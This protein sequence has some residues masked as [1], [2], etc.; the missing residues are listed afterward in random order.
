[1]DEKE[2]KV[3]SNRYENL[4]RAI[5]VVFL[6]LCTTGIGLAVF[7]IF[8]FSVGGQIMIENGYYYLLL[9]C[10][11]PAGFL[12]LPGRS[13]D[14]QPKWYDLLLAVLVFGIGLYLFFNVSDIAEVGWRAPTSLPKFAFALGLFISILEGTRRVGGNIYFAVVIIISLY[15]VY[16]NYMPGIFW[17]FSYSFIDTVGFYA[18]GTEGILGIPLDVMGNIL[19]GFLLF[20]GV[21]MAT[22]GGKFFL[23]ISLALLGR[24]RG[25]PAKVAVLSSGLFGSLSGSI[26]SNVASTGS[27]TIPAMKRMGYPPHYAGAI[28]ACASTGGVLMPPVMG[29]V[30]FV[31]CSFLG[32]EY[33]TVMAAAFI[34]SLLYYFG[35]LVQVDAYAAKVGFKGLPREELPSIKE[36]LKEGWP[37]IFALLFL[38]WGLLYMRWGVKAAFYASALMF[39]LS[40]FRRET[41]LTPKR[42]IDT[43]VTVGSLI[44]QTTFLLLPMG[45]I[46][47]G[48]MITGVSLSF[49]SGFV[50][51]G[52]GNIYLILLVGVIACYIL[53]MVGMSIP[54]YIFLAV[55]MAPAIMEASA[56]TGGLNELAVHLFIIYYAMLAAITPPVAI[57]AFLGANMAGAPPLKT[58]FQAMRLG[59]VIYFIPFFFVFHPALILQGPILEIIYTSV[60]SFIGILL[61]GSGLEGYLV[62]LGKI[63]PLERVFLTISGFLISFPDL[64]T[65]FIGIFLALLIIISAMLLRRKKDRHRGLYSKEY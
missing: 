55:T 65:T 41:M 24:F 26:L 34:P 17:G 9:A 13:K 48:L 38:V 22:G 3:E 45:F 15:P 35:L 64:K 29:A 42:I 27:F 4:P 8:G 59:I 61:I 49:T 58:A 39:L 52:G 60:S 56:A 50:N 11:V 32:V 53:G 19:I 12:I 5:K 37:F 25:G 54:A 33:A 18:F 31:M 63:N 28:E 46:I 16:S 36:T 43:L 7:Q 30:A 47:C 44:S 2:T 40:F 20:A 10:F 6:L 21:M 23:S 62:K 14:T 51:L 57:A 1:M